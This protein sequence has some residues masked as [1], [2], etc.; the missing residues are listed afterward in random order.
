MLGPVTPHQAICGPCPLSLP[1]SGPQQ[2]FLPSKPLHPLVIDGPALPTQQAV[3]HPPAPTDVL[4]GNIPEAL[5]QLGLLDIDNLA[6]MALGAAVLPRHPA[7][8]AF[9]SPVTLLQDRDGPATTFRAQ[10][11][12][13]KRSNGFAGP[14]ARALPS[15]ARPPLEAS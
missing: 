9:R 15:P 12:P 14:A 2:V 4:S 8:K 13:S 1:G 6:P 10:K 5:A 3:G 11:L 7:D